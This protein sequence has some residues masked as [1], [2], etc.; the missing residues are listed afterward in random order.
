MTVKTIYDEFVDKKLIIDNS[1]QRRKVWMPQDNIRL[2][3]TIILNL[4][5]PE[6]F[7]WPAEIN[8]DT[9][10]SII[11]IVDGQQRINAII[12]FISGE[13]KLH[14]KYL[15]NKDNTE[16]Y[17]NKKFIELSPEIRTHIWTIK[18]Q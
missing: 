8:P 5:I 3:E 15:L 7:L 13:Y 16:L 6:I 10:D 9:G 18:C 4:V 17:A 2:I 1:Y 14:V 12:D 11:H